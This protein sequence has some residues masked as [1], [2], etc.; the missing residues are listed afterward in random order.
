[1]RLALT[2]YHKLI[3]RCREDDS[4]GG[5][6][7]FV[8]ENINIKLRE[9][10]SIFIPHVFESIFIEILSGPNKNTIVGVIYRPNTIPR[11][12]IDIFTSTLFD[13]MNIINI[14]KKKSTIMGDFNIDLLKYNSHEK[15]N[16]YVDNIFSQGFLPL[17]TKPTRVTS[18]SATLIDH[19]YSNDICSNST[20]GIVLTDVADHFGIFHCIQSNQTCAKNTHI[21]KRLFTERNMSIFK[22]H[23]CSMNTNKI[24]ESDCP[25]DAY[26]Q[27]ITLY[28]ESFNK[29]FPL[30]SIKTN[31][32]FTK[33]EPWMSTG[34]LTSL[35]TKSKLFK[36]KL[37]NPT[38]QNIAE[39]V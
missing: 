15:T 16:D 13:L 4:H 18:S 39:S 3:K 8:K 38:E 37:K 28:K 11:A 14:E 20:S 7:L 30:V 9:D 2:G 31:K 35:R 5:V 24:I 23:L 26:N 10:L 34:L 27:F 17:I 25:D 21:K 36:K 19:I 12:D 6:G 32:K 29:A 22:T 33:R 1:M